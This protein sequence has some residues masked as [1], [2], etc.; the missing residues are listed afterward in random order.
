MH[1][2]GTC[3]RIYECS[4]FG[5]KHEHHQQQK[6]QGNVGASIIR[7]G[8]WGP[9]LYYS[10]NKE[11]PKTVLA[12]IYNPYIKRSEVRAVARIQNFIPSEC[13]PKSPK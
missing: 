2:Y 4:G 9:I 11:P 12:I 7:T 3:N 1:E 6:R 5:I 10:Y 13:S 8:F